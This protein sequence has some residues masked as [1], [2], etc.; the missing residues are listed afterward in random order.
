MSGDETYHWEW[1]RHPALGYYDH[2]GLTAY[3][4]RF[5][6]WL[7]GGSTAISVRFVALM[8]LS[9]TSVV[10]FLLARLVTKDRGG[11]EVQAERA[12]FF[13]G[14]FMLVL[15]IYAAFPSISAPIR[16]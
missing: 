3:L 7:F 2:P 8:M 16:R 13:A 11:S 15:P 10:C 1:S 6:T 5:S 9:L 12:G 14:L 4:I